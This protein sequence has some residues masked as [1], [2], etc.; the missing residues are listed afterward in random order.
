MSGPETAV[1]HLVWAP[2]G[3][4]ELQGFLAA[5]AQHPAGLA[6]RLVVV[7]NGFSGPSDP[8]LA[9]VR[10]A[11]ADEEHELLTTA[12]PVLDLA[13]YGQALAEIE[14]D[15]MC[16][17]NSYSR[18]L[19]DGWLAKLAAPLD[20]HGAGLTGTGGSLESAYSAAPIWLK[21]LRRR[22][23]SP[24]PNP[25]LRSNGFM[26]ERELLRELRW[27]VLDSKV[28]TWAFESLSEKSFSGSCR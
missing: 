1:V 20:E 7:C 17:L 23:F 25:H 19:A 14:V 15:R 22:M 2:L 4:G 10:L 13:A 5:C 9:E 11:L 3:A 6:H 18:P 26:I 16:F 24:F 27:P 12:A 28:A 21:P 8:R